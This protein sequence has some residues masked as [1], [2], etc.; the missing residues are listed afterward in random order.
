[1]AYQTILLFGPPGSGKGTW[2]G[3]LGKIP[4]F[5]H[6]SSGDMFRAL[7]PSSKMGRLALSYIQK[8]ELVPDDQVLALWREHMQELIASGQFKPT[9]DRVVLDGLPRTRAQAERA[10]EDLDVQLI[11]FLD[12][13]DRKILVKRLHGRAQ[14]E[15]RTDD[16]NEA[17]IRHRFEV[18]DRQTEETLAH[19]PKSLVE[20]VDVS[21]TPHKILMDIG[22]VLVKRLDTG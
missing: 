17:I 19:Y 11:L 2:G 5:C 20:T 14:A 12:C 9:E 15:G 1:M 13:S 18:Y 16:A 8:G 22:Q 10:A 7:T 6:V 21:Q 4:G 3:V